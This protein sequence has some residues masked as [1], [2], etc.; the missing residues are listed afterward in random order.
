M[1]FFISIIKRAF[2]EAQ[3]IEYFDNWC[4]IKKKI[5]HCQITTGSLENILATGIFPLSVASFPFWISPFL[6]V[7]PA[8]W[9]I[10]CMDSFKVLAD[11]EM[12]P[13]SHAILPF[14]E[15]NTLA[16]QFEIS[17]FME[18]CNSIDRSQLHPTTFKTTML[19]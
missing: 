10:I 7:F 6:L 5:W 17:C 19:I 11:K 9:K 4:S 8:D 12:I 16:G 13:W 1:G 2:V 15:E 3:M 18:K 14:L